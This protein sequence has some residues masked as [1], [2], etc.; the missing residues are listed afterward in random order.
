[1]SAVT[2][3]SVAT[4]IE[5]NAHIDALDPLPI[6]EDGGRGVTQTAAV[7]KQTAIHPPATTET[8]N[9]KIVTQA[10][11]VGTATHGAATATAT[12]T[13]T[14]TA[15]VGETR[16]AAMTIAMTIVT[17]VAERTGI[18]MMEAATATGGE[19]Y[20]HQTRSASRHPT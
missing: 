17:V 5:A 8:E 11:T 9:G 19:A 15:V 18:V 12:A 7:P 14:E 4:A 6:G 16:A 1:M 3:T 2:E 20:R 13:V 10:V